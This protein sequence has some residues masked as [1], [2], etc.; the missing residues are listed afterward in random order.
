MRALYLQYTT[1]YSIWYLSVKHWE[2]QNISTVNR[3][4]LE[5]SILLANAAFYKKNPQM[6]PFSLKTLCKDSENNNIVY[7]SSGVQKDVP[8]F[9]DIEKSL[10]LCISRMSTRLFKF[11]RV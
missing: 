11:V 2:K 4:I 3:K 1:E 5:N 6:L 7:S 9:G 10:A 8:Y